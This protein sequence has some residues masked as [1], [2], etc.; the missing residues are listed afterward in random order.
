MVEQ[1][2]AGS[3][4]SSSVGDSGAL[5]KLGSLP[6]NGQGVESVMDMLFDAPQIRTFL[7]E[8]LQHKVAELHPGKEIDVSDTRLLMQ[9]VGLTRWLKMSTKRWD[10]LIQGSALLLS[11]SDPSNKL[12]SS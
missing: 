9:V 11:A 12:Y 10:A 8:A 5:H 6:R 4:S 3:G 2:K 1:A 7:V